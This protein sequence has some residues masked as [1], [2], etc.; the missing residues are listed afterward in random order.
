MWSRKHSVLVFI[1]RNIICP[2][3]ASKHTWLP[4]L[5]GCLLEGAHHAH[6][7]IP[8]FLNSILH[9]HTT[10]GQGI[11]LY[12]VEIDSSRYMIILVHDIGNALKGHVLV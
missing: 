12:E 5:Q 7:D 1:L 6:F 2:N 9:L 10:G 11:A 3:D 8:I 4:F